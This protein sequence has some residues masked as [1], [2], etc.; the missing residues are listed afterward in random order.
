[1]SHVSRVFK[2]VSSCYNHFMTTHTY[3]AAE[4]PMTIEEVEE[5]IARESA[6]LPFHLVEEFPELD[7]YIV[8]FSTEP[9]DLPRARM[10]N[11]RFHEDR[12]DEYSQEMPYEV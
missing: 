5:S 9:L 11:D 3:W 7:C 12:F 2:P 10:L 6:D 1:M 8:H 4:T